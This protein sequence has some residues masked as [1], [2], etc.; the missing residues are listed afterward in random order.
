MQLSQRPVSARVSSVPV[1]LRAAQEVRY[2]RAQS[3]GPVAGREVEDGETW[4]RLLRSSAPL[5]A[6]RLQGLDLRRDRELLLARSDLSDIVVL[7][8][9]LDEEIEE[10]LR[11]HGTIIFPAA[12][13]SPVDPY[14]AHLYTPQELY[15]GLEDDGYAGTVDARAYA[16]FEDATIRHDAYVTALRAIHDDAMSDALTSLVLGRVVVGVMGGH[17]LRRGSDDFAAAALLGHRLAEAGALVVTGGGPGAMEAANLGAWASDEAVLADALHALAGVPDFAPDIAAWVRPALAQRG[18]GRGG[19]GL[20]S[21]GIPTWYYGHEPPNAFA[22]QIAKFFS[23]AVREDLLLAHSR[24]GLVVLPGAAGTVQEVFQMAT[25]LYYEVDLAEQPL[26]PLVLVGRA[27]WTE[28][29]PV[30]PLL[31]A[32]ARERRMSAV[33]HLVDT[34]D[35]A[36]AVVTHGVRSR[37]PAVRDQG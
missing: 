17:A 31:Q 23:N 2:R 9:R 29:L 1:G 16:W 5:H 13:R 8:G 26:P 34:V 25:R 15:A 11:E 21:L 18:Q 24:D 20:R 14:R 36:A 27:H 12:H 19:T 6:L 35:E 4:A 22:Q 28:Q 37:T 30:W 10:H 32:L 33:L 7:G 3:T